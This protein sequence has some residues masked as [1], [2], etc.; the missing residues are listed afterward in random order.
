MRA[1]TLRGA[2]TGDTFSLPSPRSFKTPRANV[3]AAPA[4]LEG[5]AA[6]SAAAAAAPPSLLGACSGLHTA[7]G[8]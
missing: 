8:P 3:A 7:R 2:A 6:A 5:L 1:L 4:C